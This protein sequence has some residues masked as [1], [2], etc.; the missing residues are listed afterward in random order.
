MKQL[1]LLALSGY[2]ST[3]PWDLAGS[4]EK[5]PAAFTPR[6]PTLNIVARAHTHTHCTGRLPAGKANMGA[7]SESLLFLRRPSSWLNQ[8]PEGPCVHSRLPAPLIR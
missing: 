5:L 8:Q 2:S 6:P 4:P 7:G 1:Q 3:A